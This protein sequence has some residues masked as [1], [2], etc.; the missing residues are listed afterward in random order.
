MKNL[1]LSICL[2]MFC[3]LCIVN[4]NTNLSLNDNISASAA[5]EEHPT[6][7]ELQGLWIYKGLAT[8]DRSGG[9]YFAKMV[10]VALNSQLSNIENLFDLQANCIEA[11]V[12]KNLITATKDGQVSACSYKY[13]PSNGTI[14]ITTKVNGKDVSISG[15]AVE[16]GTSLYLYF[17]IRKLIA[18][19]KTVSPELKNNSTF[20]ALSAT[21]SDQSGIYLGARF[22][23]K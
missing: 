5:A 23:K 7:K 4:A 11:K 1:F 21:F 18:F 3:G 19:A 17:D 16:K 20:S 15:L 14:T 9:D 8:S 22:S 6:A 12:G 13:T 2:S 10:I